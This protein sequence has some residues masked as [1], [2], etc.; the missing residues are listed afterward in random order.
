M[1]RPW[2]AA[3]RPGRIS[4]GSVSDVASDSFSLFSALR[5]AS[6][7]AGAQGG[8]GLAG[9]SAPAP[10]VAGFGCGLASAG[11]VGGGFSPAGDGSAFALSSVPSPGSG[12]TGVSGVWLGS[13]A[14][15]GLAGF[16]L[17]FSDPFAGSVDG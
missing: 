12:P 15:T 1:S 7:P 14:G 10:A 4:T 2:A 5:A 8:G 6:G 17:S 11:G 3:G 9:S 13:T 16:D